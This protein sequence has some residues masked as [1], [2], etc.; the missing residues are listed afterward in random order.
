MNVL[1]NFKW[2]FLLSLY[3]FVPAVSQAQQPAHAAIR[4]R[5]GGSGGALG[6]LQLLA[7]AF[8]KIHPHASFVIVP[9]LGSGGGIKAL[10]A[11]AIDLAV[12]SRPLKDSERGPGIL[13][14]EYART[15]VVFAVAVTTNVSAITT[16]ELVSIYAGERKTWADGQPLRLV[17]RPDDESDTEIVRSVSPGMNQ[18][19]TA[20]QARQGMIIALTDK[21]N[22]ESLE[23]IP[24]AVGTTTLAQIISEKRG[25]RPLALDGDSPS[26]ATLVNGKYGYY[27]T[28]FTVSGS[29]TPPS[30][31]QFA[32]FVRSPAGRDILEKNGHWVAPPKWARPA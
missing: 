18:A 19:V 24:G 9:S 21:A 29:W 32:A 23:T 25:L 30:A 26:L 14:T 10:Q 22:A 27:K 20:A 1:I 15:P 12:I 6:T 7:D 11:G 2:F 8:K 3:L 16:P 17:L 4:I 5:I 31:H 28:F 13:A